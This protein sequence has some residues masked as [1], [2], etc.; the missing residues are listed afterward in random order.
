MFIEP[1]ISWVP[2]GFSGYIWLDTKV[3]KKLEN[4]AQTS[5]IPTLTFLSHTSVF[6]LFGP[7]QSSCSP[8]DPAILKGIHYAITSS[9]IY[10]TIW[11]NQMCYKC[12]INIYHT[13]FP[14]KMTLSRLEHGGVTAVPGLRP[15]HV[16]KCNPFN[17]D[18]M[19]RGVAMN[20][21]RLYK[22]CKGLYRLVYIKYCIGLYTL[23]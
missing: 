14:Q 20:G 6:S 16:L 3:L 12:L 23:V 2:S 19:T 1:T 8:V 17:Y 15:W 5:V 13:Q 11:L 4:K 10:F 22:Y 9:E 21:W 18:R 7:E